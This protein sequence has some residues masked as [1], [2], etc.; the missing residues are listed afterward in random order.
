MMPKKVATA[1]KHG[2]KLEGQRIVIPRAR[3]DVEQVFK[4]VQTAENVKALAEWTNGD[5]LRFLREMRD[6]DPLE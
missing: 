4:A 5:T 6:E 2:A 1:K 3:P